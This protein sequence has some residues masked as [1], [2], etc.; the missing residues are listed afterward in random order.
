L[1]VGR[2][3]GV[4]LDVGHGG[5]SLAWRVAVPIVKE[6]ILP[7]TISTDLHVGSMNNGMK[8]ML[9]VMSKFLALGLTIDEVIE[10]ATWNPARAIKQDHLGHLS[11]G[12][13]AD[14]AVLRVEKGDFGFLDIY[15]AKLKGSQKL[16]CEM[17]LRDGKIVY[18]LNGLGRPDW[19]SLPKDHRHTGDPRWDGT[20]RRRLRGVVP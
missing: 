10:R 16:E 11:V 19:A 20:V 17:T 15:N 14:I 7:D 18:D 13:G 9:N 1:L 8:D 5:G 12:A 2:R 6:G 4:L 3:R